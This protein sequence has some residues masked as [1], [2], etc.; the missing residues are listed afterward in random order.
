M[1]KQRLDRDQIIT[2]YVEGR[3]STHE[4]ARE[5]GNCTPNG[6]AYLLRREGIQLRTHGGAAGS[7]TKRAF[8]FIPTRAWLV[9][10][11]AYFKGNASACAKHYGFT[12]PSFVDLLRKHDIP[13]LPPEDRRNVGRPRVEIPIEEAMKLSDEGVTYQALAEKYNVTY[14]VI[15]RRMQEAGHEA[16]RNKHK[17]Y[18][19]KKTLPTPKRR[20]LCALKEEFGGC[21][22]CGHERSLDLAHINAKKNGGELVKENTLLL[23]PNHHRLFDNGELTKEEF[24]KIRPRVRH[25]ETTFGFQNDLYKDW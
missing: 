18:P 14:G 4:I 7:R 24:D 5:L 16:P 21:E 25:A 15:M 3:K 19:G 20:L 6:V 22:I 11:M 8:G 13:R 23:C 10:A 2:M 17:V 9:E 12:Y 1:P